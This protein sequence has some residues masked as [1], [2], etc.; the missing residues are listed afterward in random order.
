MS[1][2][3]KSVQKSIGGLP[4]NERYIVR[5]RELLN[6]TPFLMSNLEV[7]RIINIFVNNLLFWTADKMLVEVIRFAVKNGDM[8]LNRCSRFLLSV[9]RLLIKY[10]HT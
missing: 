9:T 3:Y 5:K 2:M 10:K 7:L 8:H 6:D 4:Y 1:G